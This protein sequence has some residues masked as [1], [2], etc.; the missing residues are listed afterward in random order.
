M[1]NS[2]EEE[3]VI[4]LN[5]IVDYHLHT[6]VVLCISD[7]LWWIP[8]PEC[9]SVG[10]STWTYLQQLCMDTGCSLENLSEVM[11]DRD[12]WRERVRDIHA[13]SMTWWWWWWW[14]YTSLFACVFIFMFVD[15]FTYICKL[16]WLSFG[17]K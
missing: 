11:D 5:L 6:S 14:L 9:A 12:K 10:Q 7:I 15:M 1:K 17:E 3:E 2:W 13:H 8:S 16:V 4:F